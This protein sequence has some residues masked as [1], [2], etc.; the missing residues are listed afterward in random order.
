MPELIKKKK[1]RS[2]NNYSKNII[3]ADNRIFCLFLKI[4]A[5]GY[6]RR[7]FRRTFRGGERRHV[8][9]RCALD[10]DL[11]VGHLEEGLVAVG[12]AAAKGLHASHVDPVAIPRQVGQALVHSKPVRN[13]NRRLS[14]KSKRI[15]HK[16]ILKQLNDN[17]VLG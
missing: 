13:L 5:R 1:F 14:S 7:K 8:K 16:K 15:S 6:L 10:V 17:T 2:P 9:R 4:F 11:G 3:W 12:E